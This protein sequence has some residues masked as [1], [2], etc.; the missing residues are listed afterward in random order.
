MSAYSNFWP[1]NRIS[2]VLC[3]SEA[4]E[5]DRTVDEVLLLILKRLVVVEVASGAVLTLEAATS[6]DATKNIL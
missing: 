5:D 2:H 4:L 1:Q 3:S 6:D